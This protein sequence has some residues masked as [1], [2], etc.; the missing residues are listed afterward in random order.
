MTGIAD[1]LA[2]QSIPEDAYR[3]ASDGTNERIEY[4]NAGLAGRAEPSETELAA[5]LADP[6]LAAWKAARKAEEEE[7]EEAARELRRIRRAMISRLQEVITDAN[8]ATTAP[9]FANIAAASNAHRVSAA[10]I[11]D[12][13]RVLLQIVKRLR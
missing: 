5:W 2:W 4:W 1:A 12:M 13:A 10:Q 11:R 8:T 3:V 9:N 7:A 6:A